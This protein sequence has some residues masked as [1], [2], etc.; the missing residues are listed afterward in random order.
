MKTL[1][2]K[3]GYDRWAAVYDG[4]G[5]P[6][7]ALEEARVAT[8]VGDARGLRVVD[9]GCGTGRH[10][11]QLAAAGARRALSAGRQVRRVAAALRDA[12]YFDVT[13]S[14]LWTSRT[15][16]TPS[17]MSSATRFHHRSCTLPASVTSPFT[18]STSTSVAS[19]RGSSVKR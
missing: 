2:A 11:V 12:P 15:P 16:E 4:E 3:P 6:L 14:R 1:A 9:V 13:V 18:T 7:V 19:M 5:N 10:A 17:A 8:M